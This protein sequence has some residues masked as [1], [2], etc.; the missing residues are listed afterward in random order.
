MK[1]DVRRRLRLGNACESTIATKAGVRPSRSIT[2]RALRLDEAIAHRTRTP[3][4]RRA[5]L[6]HRAECRSGSCGRDRRGTAAGCAQ[7]SLHVPTV[8][9]TGR[10]V[11]GRAS[12]RASARAGRAR[13][14]QGERGRVVEAQALLVR[15]PLPGSPMRRLGIDDYAVHVEDQRAHAAARIRPAASSSAASTTA[16]GA[17]PRRHR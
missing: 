5:M 12:A 16:V 9:T 11:A 1:K 14:A 17:T 8:T 2:A 13:S 7:A 4:L 3:A 6:P 15:Q 10:P